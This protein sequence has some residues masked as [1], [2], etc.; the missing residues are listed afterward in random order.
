[1]KTI[2]KNVYLFDEL[3]D[4]QKS[5]VIEKHYDINVD[6]GWWESVYYDA[7]N[8]GL[9]ITG[10]DTGRSN[11]ITGE[12]LAKFSYNGMAQKITSEHGETCETHKTANEYLKEQAALVAKYSD[13]KNLEIVAEDNE[14]DYDNEIE[15]IE[16]DF[17]K[18]LLQDYLIILRN[19]YEYLTSEEA[20]K[21][22]LIS[23]EYYF[24]E[25]GKI[26]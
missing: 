4:K 19:E 25:N 8:I 12:L 15:E 18:S 26:C 23:N 2:C 9:E 10:F 3:T 1:M 6:Y 16:H 22:M 7:A 20:I 24:D 11:D 5:K 17:L 13:G 14:W 21:E